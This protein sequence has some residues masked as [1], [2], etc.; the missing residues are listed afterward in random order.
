MI[1]NPPDVAAVG[2]IYRCWLVSGRTSSWECWGAAL[3]RMADRLGGWSGLHQWLV[4]WLPQ[5]PIHHAKL[6]FADHRLRSAQ[7]LI[8]H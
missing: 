3:T 1:L 4:D 8:S 6:A 2:T 5:I 7:T